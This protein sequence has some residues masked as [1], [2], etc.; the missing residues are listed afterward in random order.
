MLSINFVAI[1]VGIIFVQLRVLTNEGS[2]ILTDIL[3]AICT[4]SGIFIYFGSKFFAIFVEYH[5]QQIQN[6]ARIK[7]GAAIQADGKLTVTVGMSRAT[8]DESVA[9][10]EAR[11][12]LMKHNK[13]TEKMI[14]CQEQVDIWQ[15]LLLQLSDES[16]EL[17]KTSAEL[18][19]RNISDLSAS[20]SHIENKTALVVP[21]DNMI[22][23]EEFNDE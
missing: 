8:E 4:L 23:V 2:T 12:L 19:L 9:F 6:S 11:S 1:T 15:T 16:S 21:V 5:H 22:V 20:L 17:S 13:T 3:Y 7:P 10:A 14:F 18:Q